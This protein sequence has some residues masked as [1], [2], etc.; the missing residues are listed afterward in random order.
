MSQ[1]FYYV[2]VLEGILDN[3]RG[4]KTYAEIPYF[5]QQLQKIE[6]HAAGLQNQINALTFLYELF[7]LIDQ[8]DFEAAGEVIEKHKETINRK[9]NLGLTIR[10]EIS[11]YLSIIQIGF[12]N[13]KSA[14]KILWKEIVR[15]NN[16]YILP[17]YRTIRLINLIAHYELG[18]TDII[19][20]ESR[21]IKREISKAGKGY[22][23]EHIIL[24]FMTKEKRIM[25]PKDREKLQ[26]KY[27][28]ILKDIREDVFEKQLLK[29]FDFTA[30]IESRIYRK[31]LSDILK[32]RFS[33]NL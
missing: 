26:K 23:V 3:L 11:L 14:Q 1:P 21:S 27:D 28:A 30:W 18:N 10:A 24:T 8:G 9:E 5:V 16:I 15:G 22:R 20:I 13:Y 2:N 31:P 25:L 33:V 29:S 12:R 4:M 32:A 6:A 7:P 19:A 17:V